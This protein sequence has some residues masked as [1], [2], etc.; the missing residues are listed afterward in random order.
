MMQMFGLRSS[1]RTKPDDAESGN[2]ASSF[3]SVGGEGVPAKALRLVLCDERGRFKMDPEAVA[4]LQLVKGP[5]GVVSVCGRARQGKS[6]ILNQVCNKETFSI[7]CLVHL[8]ENLFKSHG[9]CTYIVT[10]RG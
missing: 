9:P 10:G 6:F 8:V 2:P 3:E 1:G 4:A 5:L 7:L